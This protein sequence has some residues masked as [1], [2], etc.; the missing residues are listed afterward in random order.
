[1]GS[2]GWLYFKL[3]Y[4]SYQMVWSPWLNH[5]LTSC[6][7]GFSWVREKRSQILCLT[8]GPGDW[9][10]KHPK[11]N[12][13]G[14]AEL[15]VICFTSSGWCWPC[16]PEKA[17]TSSALTENSVWPKGSYWLRPTDAQLTYCPSEPC[18]QSSSPQLGRFLSYSSPLWMDSMQK[19]KGGSKDCLGLVK[20]NSSSLWLQP[21]HKQRC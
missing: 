14:G 10:M 1:M 9:E 6:L 17:G 3:I 16:T 20:T 21:C 2:Q 5:P 18:L 15:T 11:P 8:L 4:T 13:R 19:G 7:C 12:V